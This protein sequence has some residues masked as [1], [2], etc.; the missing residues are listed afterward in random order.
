MVS[1]TASPDFGGQARAQS[2]PL[3][4]VV[5]GPPGRSL[6]GG[7][8]MGPAT[9]GKAFIGAR[10]GDLCLARR[11]MMLGGCGLLLLGLTGHHLTRGRHMAF[12]NPWMTTTMTTTT[13]MRRMSSTGVPGV[14]GRSSGTWGGS[15]GV[16]Q[17]PSS[18]P[19][20]V[21]Q[22]SQSDLTIVTPFFLLTHLA[23]SAGPL[24]W[25]C[26]LLCCGF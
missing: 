6:T 25:L 3:P 2:S 17:R 18:G 24:Q 1:R 22:I 16:S 10:H 13:M 15:S 11:R 8:A 19:R 7:P 14:L 12:S 4:G 9:P 26:G 21:L 23:H 20:A 5:V